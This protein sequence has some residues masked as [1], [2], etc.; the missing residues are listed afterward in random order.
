[1]RRQVRQRGVEFGITR[2]Q[3]HDL[4]FYGFESRRVAFE[5][6]ERA[7]NGQSLERHRIDLERKFRLMPGVAILLQFDKQ[8]RQENPRRHE[9]RVDK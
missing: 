2:I 5:M 8:S 3:L 1:L 9:V 7:E 4:S 6:I